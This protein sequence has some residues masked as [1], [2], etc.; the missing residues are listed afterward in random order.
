MY[1]VGSRKVTLEQLLGDAATEAGVYSNHL[2]RYLETLQQAEELA[3]GL[4]KVVTSPEPVELDSMQIYKLHS[5]G[6][7]KR[8]DNQLMPRC[9]LYREYFRR[10]L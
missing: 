7:V 3:Q 2:R 10:V 8:Q 1:E 6:L 9:N 4:K 5:M